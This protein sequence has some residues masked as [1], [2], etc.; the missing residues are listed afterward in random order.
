V[1]T[2]DEAGHELLDLAMARPADARTR[3]LAELAA[4][5]S[6]REATYA[7]HA[8]AIVERDVGRMREAGRH[9]RRGLGLARRHHL[10]DRAADMSATLGSVL[11][12]A[13]RTAAA[14]TAFDEALAGSRGVDRARV[15]VR[16]AAIRGLLLGDH[17]GAIEDGNKAIR[18]LH[19]AGETLWESRAVGNRANSYV[20]LGRLDKARADLGRAAGMLDGLGQPYDAAITRHNLAMVSYAAGDLVGALRQIEQAIEEYEAVEAQIPEAHADRCLILLAAGLTADAQAAGERAVELMEHDR[21]TA[22]V[23]LAYME[24]AAAGAALDAGDHAAATRHARAAARRWRRAG[25]TRAEVEAD[26]LR[27]RAAVAAGRS[28]ARAVRAGD[29]LSSRLDTEH[30][31]AALDAHLLTG[32]LA[33][34]AGKRELADTH[35]AT[36]AE[37]RRRGS[38]LRRATG[39]VAVALQAQE[40]EDRTGLLRAADHGLAVL[41]QHRLT[42]GSSELRARATVRGAELARLAV[43]RA[44]ADGSARELLRWSERWR[45]TLQVAPPPR[46][47]QDPEA[48]AELA[49]LRALARMEG[50]DSNSRREE[51]RR[52][53]EEAVRR[54]ELLR[55]GE[56]AGRR[57]ALDIGDL[58]DALGGAALVS[59]VGVAGE[60]HAVVASGGRVRRVVAGTTDRVRH[61]VDYA[62]LA[63]RGAARVGSLDVAAQLLA[64]AEPGLGA[65]EDALLGPALRLVGDNPV[66]LV[67]PTR[68][69]SAPWGAMPGLRERPVTVAPSASSWLRAH[70]AIVPPGRR[71]ALVAG[72][73]L[74]SGAAEVPQLARRYESVEVLRNGAAT[75]DA[76]LQALDGAWLGHVAAHGTFR[77]DNPLFSTLDLADGPMTVYDLDGL[78]RP[79]HRLVL[80][81]CESGAAAPTGADE[82]LGLAS[83]LVELGTA[84]MVASVVPVD[85][86]ATVGFSLAAHEAVARGASLGEAVLRARELAGDDPVAQATAW[87]FLALGAA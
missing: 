14:M 18:T 7:L 70:R 35:L 32:R 20:E 67:P 52:R 56:A 27:F 81:A 78:R 11:A 79:P 58:L 31:T 55:P 82:L 68:L 86:A 10:H 6:P 9:L 28:P 17:E 38:A 41:E 54:R 76:T 77:G 73:G 22:A 85:D 60:V 4:R 84:G 83:S 71:V 44:A 64:G 12:Y 47:P 30:S 37:A 87:S 66:I 21:T 62:L 2:A 45:A 50:E 36:A 33:L 19:R 53:L 1:A 69:H 74:V 39:W 80:S 34:S 24:S 51:R 8:L 49:A 3:A 72:P 29:E 43:G 46:P 16:R 75:C 23:R 26:F 65:L 57:S 13:G 40:R 5:P 63:V 25:N 48:L 42:L 59:V 15:L 61:E